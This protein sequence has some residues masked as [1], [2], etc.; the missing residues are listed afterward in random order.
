MQPRFSVVMP[1]RNAG[2]HLDGAIES[3]LGQ[4]L[5]DFEFIIGDD[6]STDGSLERAR[7]WARLDRRI[8]LLEGPVSQGPV[9]SANWVAAAATCPVVAR[10]DADDIAHPERF[11]RQFEVLRHREDSVLVGCLFDC[12]DAAGRLVRTPDVAALLSD[13]FMPP[14]AH[15]SIMYRRDAF[16][17]VG[18]YRSHCAYFE[19]QDLYFRMAAA[20]RILIIPEVLFSYRYA[21]QSGRLRDPPAQ[22]ERALGYYHDSRTNRQARDPFANEEVAPHGRV[23][24]LAIVALGGLSLWAGK[25]PRVTR[26]LLRHGRLGFDMGTALALGWALW[27]TAAPASLR[28]AMRLHRHWRSFRAKPRIDPSRL[29][30]WRRSVAAAEAPAQPIFGLPPRAVQAER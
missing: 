11:R 3:I 24:P 27:A 5:G 28:S 25:R 4:T 8:R 6:G 7:A 1:V 2:P 26:R 30:E 19:D 9:G 15:G 22:V 13:G 17:R 10:M 29:Y 16:D 21:G 20:G 23:A 14:I 12:I 18:G